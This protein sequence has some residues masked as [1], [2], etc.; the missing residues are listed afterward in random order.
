MPDRELVGPGEETID[1]RP[2][3]FYLTHDS[4][5]T[6]GFIRLGQRVRYHGAVRKYAWWNHAG[7]FVDNDGTIIEAQGQGVRTTH[8]RRYKDRN[9][10]V[11]RINAT[12][13]DREQMVRF[14]RSQVGNRYGYTTILSLGLGLLTGLKLVFAM[15]G[16]DI[17]SGLVA[18]GLTRGDYILGRSPVHMMPAD[19]AKLFDVPGPDN[20]FWQL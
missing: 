10:A 14:Y 20:R 16:S 2:G 11:V 6:A 1:I 7:V 15:D 3:D 8:I 13:A 17:C 4:Y 18:A 12:D 9:Y 19:L 5:W